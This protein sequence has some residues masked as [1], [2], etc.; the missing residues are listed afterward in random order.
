MKEKSIQV[1]RCSGEGE[2]PWIVALHDGLAIEHIF[3][4]YRN[5]VEAI[6]FALDVVAARLE[7]PVMWPQWLKVV[8]A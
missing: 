1:Y 5:P 8:V 2:A 7:L 4:Q 6:R 3:A